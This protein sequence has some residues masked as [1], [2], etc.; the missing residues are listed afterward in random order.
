M[1]TMQPP[2]PPEN[3]APHEAFH[4]EMDRRRFVINGIH[5]TLIAALGTFMTPLKSVATVFN[6]GAFW[7]RRSLT[8]GGLW[9]AS[10]NPNGEMGDGTRVAKSSPV[11]VGALN[12]WV[13]VAS[14]LNNSA[15]IR[16]DGTLWTWGLGTS[17]QM[18][19][20]T[21]ASKS[22]PVQVGSLTNWASVAIGHPGNC[23]A[24]K[25]DGT[26]WAWGV[27][28][29]SALGNGASSNVSSPVQI[30]ALTNW[31]QVTCTTYGGMAVKTDGT[32]WSWGLGN[33]GATG[34]G[35]TA[36]KSS[37]TQ[38]GT[39]S[40]WAQVSGGYEHC[41]AIKTDGTLWA[42]GNGGSGQ[43]GDGT[44]VPKSS[45]VQIGSLTTWVKVSAGVYH[46][47]AIR[48]DG[49]LWGWGENYSGQAAG[50]Q[51]AATP[52]SP[53]QVGSLTTWSQVQAS[54]AYTFALRTDG[55]L[56]SWGEGSSSSNGNLWV[57]GNSNKSS[58]TQ[59]GTLTKWLA[60]G[61]G[62]R[63]FAIRSS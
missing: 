61:T 52:S 32:L 36:T 19:D 51:L 9:S 49:T 10:V 21:L 44:N 45:P 47:L 30:G 23:H 28:G 56:W 39:L 14:G 22:S 59:V 50:Q 37:P 40:N 60:L 13:K 26:L 7:R 24:I 1:N 53:V 29:N 18:G 38:I 20:G 34:L 27:G 41:L 11:Q 62:S 3:P 8:T 55:T 46:S 31:K 33:Y 63:V 16:A 17:G 57:G 4:P 5:T 43:L 58:P 48:S 42:W 6:T 15:A 25:T 54:Y 35:T 12:N 2:K